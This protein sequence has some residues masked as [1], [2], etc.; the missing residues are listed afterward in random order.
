MMMVKRCVDVSISFIRIRT[1]HTAFIKI[2][3]NTMLII[4][5]NEITLLLRISHARVDGATE[6]TNICDF[7]FLSGE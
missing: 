6:F 2:I 7:Y 5:L 4:Y 3:F 1:S